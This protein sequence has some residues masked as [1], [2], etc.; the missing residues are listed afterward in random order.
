M[1]I[2]AALAY[3]PLID[4]KRSSGSTA[5]LV[6]RLAFDL[7]DALLVTIYEDGLCVSDALVRLGDLWCGCHAALAAGVP[8]S[9]ELRASSALWKKALF[10]GLLSDLDNR[11][12]IIIR[13]RIRFPSYK[14]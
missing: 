13:F 2:R 7:V 8:G 11:L 3:L 1:R 12:R 4:V 14:T 5:S 6:A 9:R 10:R